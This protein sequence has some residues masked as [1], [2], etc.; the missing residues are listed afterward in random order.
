MRNVLIL[1]LW[2]AFNLPSFLIE[3]V[4]TL[5]RMVFTFYVSIPF[6]LSKERE[7]NILQRIVNTVKKARE[8]D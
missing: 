2:I 5:L 3:I 4:F 7:K 1:L 6:D 8:N